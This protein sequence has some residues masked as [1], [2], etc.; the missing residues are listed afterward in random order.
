MIWSG[1]RAIRFVGA[2]YGRGRTE[3]SRLV[4]RTK[5]L[6]SLLST[7]VGRRGRRRVRVQWCLASHVVSEE[8]VNNQENPFITK[9]GKYLCS[10][11]NKVPIAR[12]TPLHKSFLL[13]LFQWCRERDILRSQLVRRQRKERNESEMPCP[14]SLIEIPV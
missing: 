8:H 2:R 1:K 7:R 10:L 4:D 5:R 6:P 13:K 12:E 14:D 9:L 3:R 11:F